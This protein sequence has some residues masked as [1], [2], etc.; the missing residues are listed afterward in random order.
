MEWACVR[1]H[2]RVHVW[3]SVHACR[4]TVLRVRTRVRMSALPWPQNSRLVWSSEQHG[5]KPAPSTVLLSGVEDWVGVPAGSF[6]QVCGA[7]GCHW[8]VSETEDGR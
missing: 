5:R 4:C 7:L 6:V 3:K 2:R 1:T 8:V